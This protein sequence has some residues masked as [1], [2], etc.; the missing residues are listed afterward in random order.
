[1]KRSVRKR[2]RRKATMNIRRRSRK[3]SKS[4]KRRV[5]RRS[6]KKKT[7]S[8]DQVGGMVEIMPETLID[9]TKC[10]DY[11]G[12]DAPTETCRYFTYWGKDKQGNHCR[13]HCRNPD[14]V[15]RVMGA[16]CSDVSHSTGRRKEVKNTVSD[17]KCPAS[18]LPSA[19]RGVGASAGTSLTFRTGL[20]ARDWRRAGGRSGSP[21]RQ[22]D[23]GTST[24]R[25]REREQEEATATYE[26][27]TITAYRCISNTELDAIR[28]VGYMCSKYPHG[29]GDD[30]WTQAEPDRD[31]SEIGY[32]LHV[33]KGSGRSYEICR[34]PYLSFA[35]DPSQLLGGAGAIGYKSH[36]H[37]VGGES[38]R[39]IV[40]IVLTN[41]IAARNGQWVEFSEDNR[42]VSLC[43]RGKTPYICDRPVV[44]FAY[45]DIREEITIDSHGAELGQTD[46]RGRRSKPADAARNL[47]ELGIV[48]CGGMIQYLE[49]RQPSMTD[50]ERAQLALTGSVDISQG[51]NLE[52]YNRGLDQQVEQGRNT[53][54]LLSG[55]VI[56]NI[57]ITTGSGLL[58]TDGRVT[59]GD[60]ADEGS[61]APVIRQFTRNSN[62]TY[63]EPRNDFLGE[64]VTMSFDSPVNDQ[65]LF[66]MCGN[67]ESM[68][69]LHL[70]HTQGGIQ[71]RN[72][73][74]LEDFRIGGMAYR[75]YMSGHNVY[76]ESSDTSSGVITVK[77]FSQ[78]SVRDRQ[79]LNNLRLAQTYV[80]ALNSIVQNGGMIATLQQ[81]H[82]RMMSEI[83]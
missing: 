61:N 13:Y 45:A 37:P 30:S 50:M 54:T 38:G 70:I 3:P 63:Y 74:E 10:R 56:S 81:T 83:G 18:L 12:S 73:C 49:P 58:G 17:P 28:S 15:K 14:A 35:Q 59:Q 62:G 77:G 71:P 11:K 36:C 29:F 43:E 79:D 2:T 48:A 19:G 47:R 4:R 52:K 9:G 24:V 5:Y 68:L 75:F 34:S 26:S 64:Y 76:L 42:T 20:T 23:P 25:E 7:R 55:S 1:M 32:L 51:E 6:R 8:R 41:Y 39:N 53:A 82:N 60:R 46:G 57:S 72:M 65:H 66:Q 31:H 67:D 44:F 80:R 16:P 69:P 27:T 40:R 78:R 22:S 33:L 21:P